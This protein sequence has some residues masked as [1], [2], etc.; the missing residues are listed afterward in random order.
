M[1][2][3]PM[4]KIPPQIVYLHYYTCMYYHYP[5]GT[6]TRMSGTLFFIHFLSDLTAWCFH[7]TIINSS[8]I[9]R[10][11]NKGTSTIYSP[12]RHAYMYIYSVESFKLALSLSVRHRTVARHRTV[13]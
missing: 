3:I 10:Q 6:S 7:C 5:C 8:I 4:G 1:H 9:V 13:S 2:V 11:H 12:D